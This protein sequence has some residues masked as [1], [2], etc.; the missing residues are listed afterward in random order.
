MRFIFFFFIVLTVSLALPAQSIKIKDPFFEKELIRL[1]VDTNGITG[2]ILKKDA[3]K[4]KNLRIVNDG[5]KS[6][7]GLE[8]FVKL[9]YLELQCAKLKGRLRLNFA[10]RLSVLDV[11]NT[12]LE[13]VVINGN[14]KLEV[15][16][17][18]HCQSLKTLNIS[19]NTRLVTV[20]IINS[21]IGE[22][23]LSKNTGLN[24]IWVKE[25][26]NLTF[27]DLANGKNSFIDHLLGIDIDITLNPVLEVVL[28]DDPINAALGHEPYTSQEWAKDAKTNFKGKTTF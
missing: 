7:K 25:N 24:K 23:D 13:K 28:V 16:H 10:K 2:D 22:L 26:R 19:K 12:P 17:L 15:L 6:I 18:K 27:L 20:D 3:E 8:G 5:I 21:G 11:Q 1:C 4:V 14:Q 9:Q